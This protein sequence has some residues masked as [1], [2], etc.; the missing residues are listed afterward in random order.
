MCTLLSRNNVRDR[1]S[2]KMWHFVITLCCLILLRLE[3]TAYTFIGLFWFPRKTKNLE[4]PKYFALML[5]KL[6]HIKMKPRIYAATRIWGHFFLLHDINENL[7]TRFCQ[8]TAHLYTLANAHTHTNVVI[9]TDKDKCT[10]WRWRSI[11]FSFYKTFR[12]MTT[13]LLPNEKCAV[14]RTFIS[15]AYCTSKCSREKIS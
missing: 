8:I 15:K 12:S 9:S 11:R 6:M 10:C 4:N 14:F 2:L 7:K 3:I 1:G 5:P 13:L